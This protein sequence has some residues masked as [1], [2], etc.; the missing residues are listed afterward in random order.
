[1]NYLLL[2]TSS[3]KYYLHDTL[4]QRSALKLN[5]LCL[6]DNHTNT[7]SGHTFSPWQYSPRN[8]L[9]LLTSRYE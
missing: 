6:D 2:Y 7:F 1:M 4:F 9:G 5:S 8:S 3:V